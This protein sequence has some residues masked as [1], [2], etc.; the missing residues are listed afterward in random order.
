MKRLVLSLPAPL[1][2]RVDALR[3]QGYTASGFIRSLLEQHFNQAPA[4]GQK[5]R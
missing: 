1:K 5:G 2:D 4:K 3:A